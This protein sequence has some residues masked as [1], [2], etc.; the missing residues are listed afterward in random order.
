MADA[1]LADAASPEISGL[2]EEARRV[3]GR[4]ALGGADFA[5]GAVGAAVRGRSGRIYTGVCADLACGL[6]FCAE[7][8][9]IAEMLKSRESAIAAV[10]AVGADGILAPCGR[11]RELIAQVHPGNMDSLVVLDAGRAVPLRELLP[12]RWLDG[13][14]NGGSR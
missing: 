8:A 10:V 13:S 6:G 2:I 11:C 14:R 7:Q 9:A 3:Q 4:F 1:S 12:E 5:S